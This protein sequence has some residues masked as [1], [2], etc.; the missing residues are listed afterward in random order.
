[1]SKD[2]R[3]WFYVAANILSKVNTCGRNLHFFIH[4]NSKQMQSGSKDFREC[5]LTICVEV[6]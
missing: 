6:K 1:M 5:V 2:F 4:S 3:I